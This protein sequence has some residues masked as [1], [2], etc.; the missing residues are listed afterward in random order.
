MAPA[1]PVEPASAPPSPPPHGGYPPP[2]LWGAY[3]QG[4]LYPPIG[5]SPKRAAIG[6]ILGDTLSVFSKELLLY[7]AVFFLY[8]AAITALT[9]ALTTLVIGSPAVTIPPPIAPSISINAVFLFLVL[10]LAVA[11]LGVVMQSVITASL[12]YFTVQRYRG[13]PVSMR[14][15]FEAGVRR[16]P[17]VLGASLVQGLLLGAGLAVGLGLFLVSLVTGNFSL[18]AVAGLFLVAFVPIAIYLT[19]ALSLYAP[20]IM[21]EGETAIASLKRSWELTRGRRATLFVVLFVLGILAIVV[22]SAIVVPL[23]FFRNAY[24]SALGT[25]ISTAITG[26]WAIIS[27]AVAYQLIVSEPLSAEP[28][29]SYPGRGP[30]GTPVVA[31]PLGNPGVARK[32]RKT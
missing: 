19:I 5:S 30:P 18:L 6:T 24:L 27:A 26:S 23:G 11:V 13:S 21:M 20:A 28:F 8:S 32:L 4:S 29:A 22:V 12:T 3:P 17:S 14:R 31:H 25:M 15:A 16:F 9:L 2:P 10:T 1:T 7:V